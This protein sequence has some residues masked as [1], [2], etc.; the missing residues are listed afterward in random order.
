MKQAPASHHVGH[1]RVSILV[2]LNI[3]QAADILKMGCFDAR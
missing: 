3:M 2:D 1:A